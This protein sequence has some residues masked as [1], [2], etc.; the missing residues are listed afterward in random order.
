MVI[1]IKGKIKTFWRIS[2]E[3][4]EKSKERKEATQWLIQ[5]KKNEMIQSDSK[6]P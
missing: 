6:Q 4:E 5:Y 1:E 2:N 3:K